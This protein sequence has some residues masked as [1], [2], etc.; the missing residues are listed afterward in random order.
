MA[1]FLSDHVRRFNDGV[2]RGD[3][4]EMVEMFAADGELVF[5]GVPVGPFQGRKAIAEAYRS[6]PPDDELIVLDRSDRDDELVAGYAWG[7]EPDTRA[8]EMRLRVED[9]EI[10]RLVVAFE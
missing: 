5:V 1:D 10:K 3:F 9:G 7:R 4:T 2:R 8:G 6:Q